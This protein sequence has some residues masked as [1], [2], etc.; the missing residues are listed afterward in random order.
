[1]ERI[2]R[3][4]DSQL[5]MAEIQVPAESLELEEP[6]NPILQTRFGNKASVKTQMMWF[7]ADLLFGLAIAA[8]IALVVKFIQWSS[9]E[10]LEL[11]YHSSV[12]SSKMREETGT[13]WLAAWAICCGVS[14]AIVIAPAL[15]I[16]TLYPAAAGPGIPELIAYLNGSV[17]EQYFSVS[18]MIVK[19]VGLIAI[20][21]S[22]M[23]S[24][25][26]GPAAHIGSIIALQASRWLGPLWVTFLH[27][28]TTDVDIS[29]H[30]NDDHFRAHVD[31]SYLTTTSRARYTV[32][33]A[34]LGAACGVAAAF[35]APL[36]GVAFVLEEAITH[37]TPAIVARTMFVTTVAYIISIVVSLGSKDVGLGYKAFSLWVSNSQTC[38]LKSSFWNIL[39]CF[40]MGVFYA[41]MGVLYNKCVLW[42]KTARDRYM[43]QQPLK[44]RVGFQSIDMLLCVLI[45]TTVVL[46]VPMS[47]LWHSCTP[48]EDPLTRMFV[49]GGEKGCVLSCLNGETYL[50]DLCPFQ[51][52]QFYRV[53]NVPDQSDLCFPDETEEFLRMY[54]YL[55]AETYS[56]TCK[57]SPTSTKDLK[58]FSNESLYP[59]GLQGL[60][61]T[62]AAPNLYWEYFDANE[63]T[64]PQ[65]RNHAG[66]KKRAAEVEDGIPFCYFQM[67]SLM[68][69]P[70]DKVLSNLL[71]RGLYYV[72]SPLVLGVFFV[73]YLFLSMMIYGIA[74]PTDLVVPNLIVGAASGRLIGLGY[75]ALVQLVNPTD[76]LLVDPGGF[77][78]LGM[79]GLWAGVSRLPF[80]VILMVLEST[81]E[82]NYLPML[83]IVVVTATL[84]GNF[85]GGSLYHQDIH[86]RNILY[87]APQPA[88]PWK[89]E[90]SYVPSV[91]SR[92]IV[93]VPAV[94]S[95]RRLWR[96]LSSNDHHGFPVMV[97]VV[98]GSAPSF[99]MGLTSAQ[100][101][102]DLEEP[103]VMDQR[104]W[105]V[106]EV[107]S[108]DEQGN[109]QCPGSFRCV[110]IVTRSSLE[111]QVHVEAAP[112]GNTVRRRKEVRKVTKILGSID[113]QEM[114]LTIEDAT[115]KPTL[116]QTV[117]D[118]APVN[119]LPLINTSPAAVSSATT[120]GK[121]Y[122]LFR[123]LK[124]RHLLVTRGPGVADGGICGIITRSDL[125]HASE[126]LG[127]AASHS[128]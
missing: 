2:K 54:I 36:A 103:I 62:Y 87:L 97:R 91:M 80:T 63:T 113:R 44:R 100:Q 53:S 69:N 60:I 115:I 121:A 15:L 50:D 77:A 119:I 96:I 78:A 16:M 17:I 22:G 86:R 89:M 26:D 41:V 71:L 82:I 107:L 56:D 112:I 122:N 43:L 125:I 123:D 83:L 39:A 34:S 116:L 68:W 127:H 79:A 14:L 108:Y 104:T 84:V 46:F 65:P 117:Q 85:F 48:R 38:N 27:K 110:G 101:Q 51:F 52:K 37:F 111:T 126:V 13:S 70:P 30:A 57:A 32:D 72:F 9:E 88:H 42:I 128:P 124:L 8:T 21:G 29:M 99:A 23:A 20:V 64:Y 49:V 18:T 55:S 66:L 92:N 19:F 58:L 93:V 31:R 5:E 10:L 94:C 7:F 102:V 40:L 118:E 76:P 25:I 105:D 4:I 67:Q 24:G 12:I 3:H 120:V 106:P 73:T 74:L 47:S 33:V 109:L 11:R 98:D 81:A 6:T 35:R 114:E 28:L 1:M 75:N 45:T 90:Q 95:K 59:Q 61:Y